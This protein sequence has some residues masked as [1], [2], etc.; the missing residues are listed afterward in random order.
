MAQK[1]NLLLGF[2][3]FRAVENDAIVK[4]CKSVKKRRVDWQFWFAYP[5]I[6]E[7]CFSSRSAHTK[8]CQKK[9]SDRCENCVDN[10]G[11]MATFPVRCGV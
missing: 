2:S 1:Y 9:V 11:E 5:A 8:L 10:N 3:G 6:I 7:V 4:N